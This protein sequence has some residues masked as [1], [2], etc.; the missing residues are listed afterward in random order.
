MEN[1]NVKGNWR[2]EMIKYSSILS[3]FIFA[4]FTFG[5]NATMTTLETQETISS[6]CRL[7]VKITG[8]Q[9]G[10]TDAAAKA[11]VEVSMFDKDGNPISGSE[12]SVT[13]TVGTFICPQLNDSTGK[14]DAD[15]RSCFITGP[16][17][18]AR[19]NLINIPFNTQV[20]VK[21]TSECGNY[22]VNASGSVSFSRKT[23][24]K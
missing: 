22:K 2:N 24:K 23:V 21:A 1:S 17:G 13:A 20:R 5:E 8:K 7:A 9:P 15:D 4:I 16:D 11:L 19:I 3:I 6:S 12:I 10:A 18:K 14:N